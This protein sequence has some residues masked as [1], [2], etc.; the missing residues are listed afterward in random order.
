MTNHL[1]TPSV[2]DEPCGGG[3]VLRV[4]EVQRGYLAGKM[5]L[6]WW[7]RQIELGRLPHVRA[8]GAILVRKADADA[9]VS[10]AYQPTAPAPSPAPA[11]PAHPPAKAGSPRPGGGLRF[12]RH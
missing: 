12:F 6:R 3:E 1:P 2:R 4:S 7:Y 11:P 10:A 9:F 8:G 5:S